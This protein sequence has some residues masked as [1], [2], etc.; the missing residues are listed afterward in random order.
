MLSAQDLAPVYTLREAT[1]DDVAYVM[2]T[3]R[4][5]YLSRYPGRR[6]NAARLNFQRL[7]REVLDTDPTV[8]VLSTGEALHSWACAGGG[9]LHYAYTPL[10]LRRN[11]LA[12]ECIDAALG[13]YPPVIPCTFKW[14]YPSARYE[15]RKWEK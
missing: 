8:I 4:D 15:F 14:P 7:V 6:R 5:S 13:G 1:A 2:A 11:G 10:E 3:W 12:R 9:R